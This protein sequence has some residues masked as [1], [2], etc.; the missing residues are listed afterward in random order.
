MASMANSVWAVGGPIEYGAFN[1]GVMDGSLPG[2]TVA[3]STDAEGTATAAE[4]RADS[5]P[6]ASD[7][8][9]WNE[10]G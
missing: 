5:T 9:V 10:P 8:I 3:G 6:G 1:V 7:C 2:L 4:S